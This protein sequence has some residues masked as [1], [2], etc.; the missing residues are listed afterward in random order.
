[1]TVDVISNREIAE[2]SSRARLSKRVFPEN[3]Y[4][5]VIF[6]SSW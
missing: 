4:H 2:K 1:M 3:S 5:F 6:V